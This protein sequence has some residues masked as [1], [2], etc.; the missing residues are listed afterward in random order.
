[1]RLPPAPSRLA[2]Q[3]RW[4]LRLVAVVAGVGLLFGGHPLAAWSRNLPDNPLSGSVRDG[5]ALWSGFGDQ[6]GLNAPYDQLRAFRQRIE[7]MRF[8]DNED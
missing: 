8:S 5:A 1:M 4:L 3:S 6:V 2:A 7:D